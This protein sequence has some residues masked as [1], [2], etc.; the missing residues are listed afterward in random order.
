MNASPL[1]EGTQIPEFE[2]E[3]EAGVI[4]SNQTIQGQLT[5]LYFYPRD[6]TPGCTLQACDLRDSYENL[7]KIPVLV[8]GISGCSC[9]S[10]Q[11]FKTKYSLPFP[12][13]LDEDHQ[14]AQSFGVWGE[15]KFM[16]KTF[17]GIHRTSFIIDKTGKIL[18]TY[19]KVKPKVHLEKVM[20]EL[21]EIQETM[22]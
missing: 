8:L 18:K 6:N 9:S 16:G 11:K 22:P 20:K 13:L 21:L 4:Y 7:L 10:H 19:K 5:L 2:T 14:I 12:L 17:D 3:D 15:K 1:N